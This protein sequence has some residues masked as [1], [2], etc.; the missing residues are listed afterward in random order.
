MRAA[1]GTEGESLSI[2]DIVLARERRNGM[3]GV[4][5]GFVLLWFSCDKEGVRCTE[6]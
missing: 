2:D 6:D 5:V 4:G 3:V 1:Y